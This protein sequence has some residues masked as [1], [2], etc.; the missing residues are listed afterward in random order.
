MPANSRSWFWPAV[1]ISKGFLG[2]PLFSLFS[3]K[4]VSGSEISGEFRDTIDLWSSP[5]SVFP[6]L[7]WLYEEGGIKRIQFEEGYLKRF[8]LTQP[9]N[10]LLMEYELRRDVFRKRFFSTRFFNLNQISRHHQDIQSKRKATSNGG[11][12]S[13]LYRKT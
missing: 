3:Q 8:S 10:V 1:R 4:D 11:E 5:R 6:L 2:Y 12:P 9:G 13:S 7:S